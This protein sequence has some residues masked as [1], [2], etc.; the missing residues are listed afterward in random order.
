MVEEGAPLAEDRV[1]FK[2][3]RRANRIAMRLLPVLVLLIA[4]SS[5]AKAV[6]GGKL[7]TLALGRWTC[8]L[9]GDAV[10]DPTPR[11]D[12]S[13]TAV[14]DSSYETTHGGRGSYLL[15][16]KRLT[17]TSGPRIG[18]SYVVESTAMVS[19]LD[20]NGTETPL[21]CVRAGDPAALALQSLPAEEKP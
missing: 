7:G 11:P 8:E 21:R 2:R 3:E 9:P 14:P 15:L 16:G 10:T 6:P 20:A 5:P 12:E 17:M 18:A 19:K 13:F 4:L 1:C